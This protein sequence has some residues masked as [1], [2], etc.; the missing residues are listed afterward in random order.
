MGPFD[1][2]GADP[3]RGGSQERQLKKQ[4]EELGALAAVHGWLLDDDPLKLVAQCEIRIRERA[5][6]LDMLMVCLRTCAEAALHAARYDPKE[7][8]E[9]WIQSRIDRAIDALIEE[10]RMNERDGAPF[11]DEPEQRFQFLANFFGCDINLTRKAC[12]IANDLPDEIRHAVFQ[13]VFL[14][15]PFAEVAPAIPDRVRLKKLVHSGLLAIT[16]LDLSLAKLPE[17]DDD[18]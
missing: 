10:D 11:G 16:A 13:T 12:I 8:L 4:F 6:L 3:P 1:L 9:A 7:P 17:D 14:A 18:E 15:R 2:P 5:V